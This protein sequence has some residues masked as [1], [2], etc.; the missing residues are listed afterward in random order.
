MLKVPLWAA[1]IVSALLSVPAALA[2]RDPPPLPPG[3]KP[4]TPPAPADQGRR[5][6]PPLP[7]GL[8]VQARGPVHEAFAEP[9]TSPVASPVV[10]RRPPAP[11]EELHPDEKPAGEGVRWIPG[12]WQWDEERNNHIW[13]SGCWRVPPPDKLWLSGRWQQVSGG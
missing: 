12:Y 1:T 8:E 2:Q 13:I 7:A 3:L 11:I 10:P 5:D 6:P 4:G 9:G